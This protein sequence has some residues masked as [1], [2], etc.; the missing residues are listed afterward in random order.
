MTN[1]IAGVNTGREGS[2]SRHAKAR[3]PGATQGVTMHRPNEPGYSQP[4]MFVLDD[5]Q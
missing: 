5:W 1:V 4:D 3:V 2:L